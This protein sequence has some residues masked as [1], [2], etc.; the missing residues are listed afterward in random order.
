MK[1]HPLFALLLLAASTAE[2]GTAPGAPVRIAPEPSA[3]AEGWWFRAAPY[4]WV[5]AIDGDMRLGP[6]RVPVEVTL[7]DTLKDLDMAVMGI[8]EAGY[9]RWSFGVDIT[10]AEVSEDLEGGGRLFRSFRL[11]QT[12]WVINP[13]LAY[14]VIES[15][16]YFMELFGGVRINGFEADVT[17]RFA[18][19]GQET[20]GAAVDW[21]DPVVGLRGQAEL[22]ERWFFRYNGDIGGFGAGAELTWQ[23][24]GGLG[25]RFNEHV[26]LGLG[27][28]A[29]AVD[30]DKNAF[31]L[32]TLTHGP[33]AGL[34][35]R[36]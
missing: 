31:A 1:L 7:E 5:T 4:G 16:D 12:Q 21:V 35:V 10:Y 6:L 34:E 15:D 17:S 26:S 20:R 23:V 3:D 29:L 13:A 22:T 14:R 28:R 24:F 33:L 2:A 30:Y 19:G 36:W 32:D 8:L 11:E 27:Y 25:F 18:G 9:G